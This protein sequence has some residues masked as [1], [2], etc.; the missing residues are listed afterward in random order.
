M[1]LH[2]YTRVSFERIKHLK[3]KTFIISKLQ[4]NSLIPNL[5]QKTHLLFYNPESYL[6][7]PK[8]TDFNFVVGKQPKGP[9]YNSQHKLIPY[10]FVGNYARKEQKKITKKKTLIPTNSNSLKCIRKAQTFKKIIMNP[11]TIKEEKASKGG[12]KKKISYRDNLSL[13]EIVDIF[14]KSKKR[15]EY[16]KTENE[17][18]NKKLFNEI[19]LLMH[20]YINEPLNQQENA[21][22]NNEK[23][24]KILKKIENNI[25][26]SFRNKY[27]SSKNKNKKN[28]GLKFVDSNIFNSTNLMK[29]SVTEYRMKIE[30]IKLNNKNKSPSFALNKHVHNWEMSLRR[31]KNFVGERREYLNVRTDKNPYWVILTEKSPLENEKIITPHINNKNKKEFLKHFYN[32]SYNSKFMKPLNLSNNDNNSCEKNNLEIK[33]KNLL[34]VEE[35]L[36]YKLNGSIKLINL[37]YDKES[38]KDIIFK[39]NYCI[40]KHFF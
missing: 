22:K 20:P 27:I 18:N 40:N 10:S 26:K 24:N 17:I 1:N 14:K 11:N 7:L 16:N 39:K 5:K 36:A 31:P 30:K 29:N 8:E 15:I 12:E 6:K 25:F 2:K 32:T 38:L 4:K 19:P 23:Y 21:L 37:K 35:K 34:D 28:N 9:R 33:G 13:T 3:K